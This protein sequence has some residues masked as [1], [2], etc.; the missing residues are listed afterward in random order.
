MGLAVPAETCG[1]L[2]WFLGELLRWNRRINLT[3]I[4]DPAEGIEKHLVDSLIP[5]PLLRGDETVL[6]IGSGGGFPGIPLKIAS[7]G[8]KIRSIDAVRKKVDFQRHVVRRL[9]LKGFEPVH[10]RIEEW[11]EK[12]G[13]NGAFGVVISRAF[14]SLV[15]FGRGSLPFLAPGGRILAMKGPGGGKELAERLADLTQAGL[16][17]TDIR[18]VTLPVSGAVRTLISLQRIGER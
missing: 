6:D 1:R 14:A 2:V 5:L 13:W 16:V 7:P 4:T 3:A 8:L 12:E 9:A 11:A 15:D 18:Y 17:C 10:G